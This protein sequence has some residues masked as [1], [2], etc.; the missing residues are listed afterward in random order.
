MTK[1]CRISPLPL[2]FTIL[3]NRTLES[4]FE[5]R[6]RCKF[7]RPPQ[8]QVFWR[9]VAP[10]SCIAK[11]LME[12]W[13]L[14]VRSCLAFLLLGWPVCFGSPLTSISTI[15]ERPR[16][17][18]VVENNWCPTDHDYELQTKVFPKRGVFEVN[19][20]DLERY[21]HVLNSRETMYAAVLVY[22]RWCP[23]SR[24]LLPLFNSLSSSFPSVYHFAVE[25]SV[26]Q[27][28]A[29]SNY[30][31]NSFPILFFHNKTTKVRYQGKRTFEG[32]S[33]FYK[34]YS[35]LQPVI[36]QFE[37]VDKVAPL[38]RGDRQL[39]TSLFQKGKLHDDVYLLLS[40]LFLL[41]RGLIYLLPKLSSLV[42]Q[43][44]AHKEVSFQAYQSMLL[45][46]VFGKFQRKRNIHTVTKCLKTDLRQETG[47]VLLS[48]PGWP[49]SSL[50]A[51]SFAEGSGSKHGV[52]G[53]DT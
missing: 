36:Y 33:K 5:L 38:N 40:F 49:S 53:G 7:K 43:Y 13:A 19:G 18:G 8:T 32:I 21:L 50:A 14:R 12:I 42:K 46:A 30:G 31:V 47:K 17:E 27:R 4:G 45:E 37:K 16:L 15:C 23:F 51:V 10:T 20:T 39:S 29:F 26:L 2:P 3:G 24:A 22:A 52:K 1:T 41:S 25:E 34:H 11:L 44:C 28:S 6:T 9:S 35:G 48:V